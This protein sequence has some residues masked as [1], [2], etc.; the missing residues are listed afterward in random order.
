MT[1]QRLTNRCIDLYVS[2][3]KFKDAIETND[4]LLISG[5]NF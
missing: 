4:K 1:L 2:D 3:E 5:S